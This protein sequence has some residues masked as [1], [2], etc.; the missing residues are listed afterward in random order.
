MT[1]SLRKAAAA[2][3]AARP[4]RVAVIDIGSN[5]LRLV[6]FDKRSRCPV[7][8]FNE[9]AQ[10]GLGRGLERDGVL[11]PE[12]VKAAL[13]NI[14]RFVTMAEAMG[15]LKAVTG[16]ASLVPATKIRV[17]ALGA[18]ARL[19]QRLRAIKARRAKLRPAAA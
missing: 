18:W 11:N 1:A 12:G 6:V 15:V 10:P 2:A 8:V 19:N 16:D 3:R 14:A 7:P 9:K 5:S 4:G 17:E 13:I